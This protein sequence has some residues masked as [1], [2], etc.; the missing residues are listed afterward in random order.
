MN[1]STIPPRRNDVKQRLNGTAPPKQ[2]L[3]FIVLFFLLVSGCASVGPNYVPPKM[4]V[5]ETW[6]GS[7]AEGTAVKAINPQALA[8]WWT[9]FQDPLL[10]ELV[11]QAV[12]QNLDIKTATSRV[13]QARAQRGIARAAY[14]PAV[15]ANGSASGSRTEADNGDVNTNE[16]YKVGFDA[17]WEID[18]FGGTRR[19]VE[20][21]NAELDASVENLRDVLVSV[22]S[23]VALNY[24]DV[25][26]YQNRL[27]ITERNLEL[28]SET[29]TITKWRAEAGLTTQLDV[30]QANY[31]L[32][33][34]RAGIPALETSLV[35]AKNRLAV[36]LG[37]NPSSLN[38]ILSDRKAI[39]V[40][41]VEVAVGVPADV[42]RR[43]PDVRHAERLLAAQ[44]AQIGVAA[45]DRFPSFA[46]SGSTG[47]ESLKLADLFSASTWVSSIASN[48]GYTL[49]DAGRIRQNITVQTELQEQA[50][51]AYESAVLTAIEEVENALTAFAGE[52]VRHRSLLEASQSAEKAVEM[53]TIQYN[54]G[55]K[56]FQ[57]LLDAQRSLLTYQDQVASSEG[58]ITSD[59]IRLYKALGGGWTP[60]TSTSIK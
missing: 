7:S 54:S 10:T 53:V 29:F 40:A 47:L 35:K 23:E 12:T 21:A 36:L 9:V 15:K 18:I 39:P 42:L 51:T 20:A 28:Q 22:A 16:L 26:S 19:S 55:Q 49:F 44:T 56:D 37:R 13:R 41:P 8:N 60:M 6:S 59:L 3:S 27:S 30:E 4:S 57:V 52:Q 45:A 31:V 17:S 32:E 46:L 5:P 33:Q 50:L 48:I 38:E 58:E 24:T 1:R 14:L 25:R 2:A 34:T 11:E 43:R